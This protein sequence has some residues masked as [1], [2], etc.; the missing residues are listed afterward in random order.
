MAAIFLASS[1]PFKV[2]GGQADWCGLK[3]GALTGPG[4]LHSSDLQLF[5]KMFKTLFLHYEPSG[6]RASDD[7]SLQRQHLGPDQIEQQW[8]K[9][10]RC[11]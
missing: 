7:R 10:G 3:A 9:L 2:H 8:Q 5:A 1:E 4:V 6:V 11:S